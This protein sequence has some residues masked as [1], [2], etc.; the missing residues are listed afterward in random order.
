[1][2]PTENVLRTPFLE[3]LAESVYS[4]NERVIFL[5]TIVVVVYGYLVMVK[6]NETQLEVNMKVSKVVVQK[7]IWGE[8]VNE[9]EEVVRRCEEMKTE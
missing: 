3:K 2:L 6:L 4:I 8:S 5:K 7:A 9:S 1:M